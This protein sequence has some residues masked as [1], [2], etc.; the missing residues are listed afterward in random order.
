MLC[1]SKS[2]VSCTCK[3]FSQALRY[4]LVSAA[5]LLLAVPAYAGE[6]V[7]TVQSVYVR[8]SDG[9]VLVL[10][11]GAPS[12]KPACATQAYWI[13]KGENT[14]TGKKQYALLMSA[15]AAGAV[16]SIVG[17]NVCTRWGDG[18]DIEVVQWN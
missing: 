10:M 14:E 16:V 1:N 4:L 11:N 18:E 9:L 12:G 13:V 15:K 3:C 7:G 8:A 2:D 17:A 5:I 6:V